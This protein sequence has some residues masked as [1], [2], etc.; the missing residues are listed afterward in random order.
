M[1]ATRPSVVRPDDD[2]ELAVDPKVVVDKYVTV[3]GAV[4]PG[5]TVNVASEIVRTATDPPFVDVTGSV[6]D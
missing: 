5:R 4:W 6:A 1:R 3:V 2:V